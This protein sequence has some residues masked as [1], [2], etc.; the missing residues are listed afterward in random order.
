MTR[1]GAGR[2]LRSMAKVCNV[3]PNEKRRGAC[4]EKGGLE[5]IAVMVA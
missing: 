5:Y 3:Q 4:K 2:L 1:M